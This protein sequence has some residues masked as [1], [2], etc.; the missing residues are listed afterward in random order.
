VGFR[1][2]R[3]YDVQ[4]GYAWA[5]SLVSVVPCVA[6]LAIELRNYEHELGQII[7]GSGGNFQLVF[8]GCL[9]AS[10]VPGAIGFLL[11]WNSAGQRRNDRPTR[12]WIGFFVGGGVLT[13]DLIMLIAFLMLRLQKPT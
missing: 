1:H 10:I 13:I 9:A 4:S 8:L 5:L 3:R 6:A 7:Y 2:L 12:S 11:G